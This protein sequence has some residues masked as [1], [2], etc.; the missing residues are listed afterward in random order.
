MR[1][2][3][4]ARKKVLVRAETTDQIARDKMLDGDGIEV[5][6][7]ASGVAFDVDD[8]DYL[9]QTG[10]VNGDDGFLVLDRNYNEQSDLGR[11]KVGAGGTAGND[12]QW[13]MAA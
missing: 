3:W 10:W 5:T 7:K 8:S 12:R 1:W 11:R 6:D 13:R 4:A 2:C 9:K